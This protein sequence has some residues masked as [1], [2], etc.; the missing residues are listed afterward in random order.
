LR[1]TTPSD[2]RKMKLDVF[3]NSGHTVAVLWRVSL[4]RGCLTGVSGLK[5]VGLSVCVSYFLYTAQ[6]LK[7]FTKITLDLQCVV[8][9]GL[10]ACISVL[11]RTS[12]ITYERKDVYVTL[13]LY[14]FFALAKLLASTPCYLTICKLMW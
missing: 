3:C 5:S 4:P 11:V 8:Y 6:D 12:L 13:S 9:V 7:V 14:R 10:L 2:K 1:A